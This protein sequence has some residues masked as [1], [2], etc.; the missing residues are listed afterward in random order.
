[1][2]AQMQNERNEGL[3]FFH[4]AFLGAGLWGPPHKLPGLPLKFAFLQNKFNCP[5]P[6]VI[7]G[8]FALVGILVILA[9]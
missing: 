6:L 2:N 5:G 8:F 1:M 9:L 4:F 3:H 7:F